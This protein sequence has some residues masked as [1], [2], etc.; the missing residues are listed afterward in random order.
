NPQT[1]TQSLLEEKYERAALVSSANFS[2]YM[3]ATNNNLHEVLKT[4][5]ANVCGIKVFMGSSTG[6]MLVDNEQTLSEIFRHAP[7][8]VATHCEDELIIRQ[9]MELARAQFGDDIPFGFHPAIRNAEACF[10]SSVKA[11]ELAARF[12]TRLHILHIS[13]ANEIELFSSNRIE[14]KKITAE[15]CVHHLWFDDEDYEKYGSQI[16]WNPAIKSACDR[17]ALLAAVVSGKIDVIASDHAPHTIGEKEKSYID[18]PSGGPLVQHTLV[19][20]LELCRHG[21]FKI[22]DVVNK[23][24][25]APARLFRINKRGFIREGY[26]ADLVLI[27]PEKPWQVSKNNILYKCGWSPFEGT[28]FNHSVLHTFVNGNP[29]YYQGQFVSQEMGARLLFDR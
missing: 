21:I 7:T 6:N 16:K 5:P 28:V 9:N 12:G 17:E 3:G 25:H 20:M 22:E 29:V 19:A 23:M 8:L 18:A 11:V 13:T 27:D 26:W 4:N 1:T 24:C 10:A 14:D 15:V 2:F